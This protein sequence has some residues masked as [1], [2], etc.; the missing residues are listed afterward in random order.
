MLDA[1]DRGKNA[2]ATCLVEGPPGAGKTA[3]MAQIMMEAAK[4]APT[5]DGGT[6]LPVRIKEGTA[7]DPV[8]LGREIDLAIVRRFASEAGERDRRRTFMEMREASDAMPPKEREAAREAERLIR[9]GV[10]EI[11]AARPGA[12]R[13]TLERLAERGRAMLRAA[14]GRDVMEAVRKTLDRGGGVAGFR[15][16]A[17]RDIPNPKLSEIAEERPRWAD[18][19][20]LLCVDE[21]Q[22]IVPH[23]SRALSEIHQ[24]DEIMRISLCVFGLLGA[25]EALRRVG[26]SR[27]QDG[28]TMILGP[29][30]DRDCELAARRCFAQFEVRGAEPW[31]SEIGARSSGWPQHLSSYLTSAMDVLRMHPGADGG[32]DAG[33]ADL[34]RALAEGD[35]A[36]RRY[37]GARLLGL[38][39]PKYR[40][41]AVSAAR[42]F[43]D[44]SAM[45][46]EALGRLLPHKDDGG[47]NDPE[48]C[49]DFIAAGIGSG[50]F[51]DD[52]FG[53][54]SMPIPSFRDFLCASADIG[55]PNPGG[56]VK[57]MGKSGPSPLE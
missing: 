49:D 4:R 2:N 19:Q 55:P 8:S 18:H 34:D 42:A 17:K 13:T 7:D 37:Y 15:I 44:S 35:A 47:P 32:L 5:S 26:I 48:Q 33:G 56:A 11:R 30:E 53:N 25:R 29:M 31:V 10:R 24:G 45:P 27:L 39:P 28:C 50:L 52:A 54:L 21:A 9:E 6:W 12:L 41:W 38:G 1:L 23:T 40:R 43:L 46:P 36:R 3:L 20:I 14:S 51:A 22:N 16:G 57:P